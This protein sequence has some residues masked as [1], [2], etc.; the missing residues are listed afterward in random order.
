[1]L[2]RPEGWFE[3]PVDFRSTSKLGVIRRASIVGEVLDFSLK[4]ATAIF[5]RRK[6]GERIEFLSRP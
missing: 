5:G 1:M 2:P 6:E 4:S 3:C